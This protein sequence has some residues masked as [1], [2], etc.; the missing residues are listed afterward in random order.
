MHVTA[1]V[2]MDLQTSQ[3]LVPHLH[4]TNTNW[5]QGQIYSWVEQQ[6]SSGLHSN[7]A[8]AE[9]PCE[10]AVEISNRKV[11]K[12]NDTYPSHCYKDILDWVSPA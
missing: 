11:H 7:A 10:T 5:A 3:A 2:S 8:R 6:A 4:R 9:S 12:K 1:L